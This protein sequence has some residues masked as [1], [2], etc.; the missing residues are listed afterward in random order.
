M[1]KKT[2][3]AKRANGYTDVVVKIDSTL[4]EGKKVVM[5]E[6]LY[7]QGTRIATHSDL[8]DEDQT[9]YYPTVKT[10]AAIG[11]KKSTE[12]SA[13]TAV[14]KGT[15]KV[16]DYVTYAGMKPGTKG[17]VTGILMDVSTGKALEVNGSTVTAEAEFTADKPEGTV[18]V[19][20]SFD[21]TDLG[22]RTLV[23]FEDLYVNDV[24]VASH[25]DLKDPLQTVKLTKPD[26]PGNPGNPG[27]PGNPSNPSTG[28]MGIYGSLIAL[29]AACAAV[30]FLIHKKKED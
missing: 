28:D 2:F 9:V 5:F 30:Y 21:A 24:K 17:K 29:A 10:N 14:A 6:D 7:Y 8:K 13:A 15:V 23:V 25:A 1:V 18:T 22:S 11:D 26:E 16:T 20:F 3:T 27:K 19:E 12:K 4:L